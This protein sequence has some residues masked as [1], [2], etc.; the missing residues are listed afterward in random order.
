MD[1]G[2]AK[3]SGQDLRLIKTAAERAAEGSLGTLGVEISDDPEVFELFN[4]GS[5]M[6]GSSPFELAVNR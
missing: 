5:S 3:F 6:P 1:G 2:L 4:N